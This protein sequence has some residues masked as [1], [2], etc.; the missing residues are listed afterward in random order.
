MIIFCFNLLL[1]IFIFFYDFLVSVFV[2]ISQNT[3][4]VYIF[5]PPLYITVSEAS[6]TWVTHEGAG[7]ACWGVP[8]TSNEDDAAVVQ[9]AFLRQ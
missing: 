4:T 8:S 6:P 3:F 1:R 7:T 5:N 2:F 9:V